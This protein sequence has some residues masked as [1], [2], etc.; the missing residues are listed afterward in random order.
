MSPIEIES[1]KGLPVTILMER[2]RESDCCLLLLVI[3]LCVRDDGCR[4]M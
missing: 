4:N 1:M 2:L 3:A